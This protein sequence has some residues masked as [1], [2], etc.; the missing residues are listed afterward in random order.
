M[1]VSELWKHGAWLMRVNLRYF[2]FYG[3]IVLLELSENS[4]QKRWTYQR[5]KCIRLTAILQ[6]PT[7]MLDLSEISRQRVRLYVI[8]MDKSKGCKLKLVP[9]NKRKCD[10]IYKYLFL[11]NT[12]VISNPIRIRVNPTVTPAAIPIKNKTDCSQLLYYLII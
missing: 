1:F 9:N 4:T 12:M 10:A 6:G 7:K 8:N 2:N 3:L 5:W 11:D